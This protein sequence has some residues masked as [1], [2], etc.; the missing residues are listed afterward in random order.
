MSRPA[1]RIAGATRWHVWQVDCRV[2][3]VTGSP[4]DLRETSIV[5]RQKSRCKELATPNTWNN[6]PGGKAVTSEPY[7]REARTH[8]GKPKLFPGFLSSLGECDLALEF[9]NAAFGQEIH[10]GR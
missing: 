6:W 2:L 5:P 9:S 7:L 1:L 4:D 8:E 10:R 3:L